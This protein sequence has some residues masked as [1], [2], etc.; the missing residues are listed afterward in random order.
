MCYPKLSLRQGITGVP[1][2]EVGGDCAQL[3]RSWVSPVPSTIPGGLVPLPGVQA[4]YQVA[5]VPVPGVQGHL[6]LR[7][8][9]VSFEIAL[10]LLSTAHLESHTRLLWWVLNAV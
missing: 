7:S 1:L 9:C 2:Y 4:P 8:W 6:S 3:R 10:P 5:F